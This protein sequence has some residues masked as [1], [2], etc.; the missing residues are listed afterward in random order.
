MSAHG[1]DWYKRYPDRFLGGIRQ[2]TDRQIAVYAV[3]LDLIYMDGGETDDNVK[4]IAGHFANLGPS[5]VRKA[6]N[7]LVGH[8]KLIQSDGKLSNKLA[9]TEAKTK[10][11]LSETRARAGKKGGENS[12][13]VSKKTNEN[14][15]TDQASASLARVRGEEIR[16]EKKEATAEIET[17]LPVEVGRKVTDIMGVTE[18]PNWFGSWA[19]AQCWLA[20]GFDPELDIY[21]T[22]TEIT[23]RRRKKGEPPP[24][25][26]KYFTKA[27]RNNFE[28][29]GGCNETAAAK[30]QVEVKSVKR[31]TREFR[32]W[33]QHLKSR[34]RASKF[35][36]QQDV[37]TVPADWLASFND[38]LRQLESKQTSER[39][40]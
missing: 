20:E 1:A 11:N 32:G 35:S 6:V 26:L 38:G 39:I 19:L 12:Q 8:H 24:A 16:E 27:I 7:D 29:R 30:P 14:N 5:A 15:E 37:L 18:D 36:E 23:A 40:Q 25:T 21:P 4:F 3:V 10:E 31:G 17:A 9:K 28:Q 2:L 13:D 34:G 22:V 33:I